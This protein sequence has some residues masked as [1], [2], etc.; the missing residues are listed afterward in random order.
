MK[1]LPQDIQKKLLDAS[2]KLP[3][4]SGF[5]VS[6]DDVAR[7]SGVPRATLY[8]YFSGKEDV[9]QFYLN[10]LIDRTQVAIEKAAATE[11]DTE[12]RLTQIMK[13]VVGAFAEYPRMCLEM[14]SAFKASP[15]QAEFMTNIDQ[16]VMDP[17][18]STLEEGVESGELVV[19]DVETGALAIMGSLHQV[20]IMRLLF[21]GRIDADEVTGLVI[22]QL[23]NGLLPR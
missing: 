9:V 6:V 3:E 2:Q 21:T 12:E 13:A 18:R 23:M 10:D 5:D 20:S 1:R 11:G 14:A 7:L 15:D 8:Y 16:T 22:P 19:G 17:L 4:G